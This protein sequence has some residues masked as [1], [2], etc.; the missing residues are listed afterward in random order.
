MGVT[1]YNLPLAKARDYNKFVRLFSE[2]IKNSQTDISLIGYGTYFDKTYDVGR[3]DVDMLVVFPNEFV[4][5][6]FSLS[7]VSKS[8]SESINESNLPSDYLNL[9]PLDLGSMLDGRLNPFENEYHL[10]N[11]AKVL[12]GA[13]DSSK[14]KYYLPTVSGLHTFRHNITKTRKNALF[15]PHIYSEDDERAVEGFKKSLDKITS[16]TRIV[17]QMMQDNISGKRFDDGMVRELF[18]QVDFRTYDYLK[19]MYRKPK[20]LSNLYKEQFVMEHILNEGLTFME[21]LS[22]AYITH[23][24]K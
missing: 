9:I 7:L 12:I 2:K 21:E 19:K 11:H 15:F 3:S 1:G 23:S 13:V 17:M 5:N 10:N 18:P 22:K 24:N 14:F 8:L 16:S 6:K 4:I 20:L